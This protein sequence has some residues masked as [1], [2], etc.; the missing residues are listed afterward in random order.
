M[1][2]LTSPTTTNRLADL[3][4]GIIAAS[5]FAFS[6]VLS[7]LVMNAGA[8]VLTLSLFRGL[9]GVA[10]LFVWLRVG[11]PP[12]QHTP[13]QRWI[14]LGLGVLF[15]GVVFG[16]FAAFHAVTVAL[17]IL[18]Y[19]VY[20]LVT[21]LLGALLGI[22]RIGWRGALAALAA[23]C[24][25]ALMMRAHPQD[26]AIAGIAFALMAAACRTAILLITR[27]TLQDA[28]PQV[29]TWYTI[30]GSTVVL[31]MVAL[32]QWNWQGPQTP[33]GWAAMIGVSVGTTIAVLALFVSIKRIGPF[34]SALVM[35]LEPLLSTVFSAPVLGEVITPI[36]AVGGAVMLAALVSFQLRR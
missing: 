25:L 29:T 13:R 33:G 10:L 20:P 8:D 6:N 11:T 17:G 15:A 16:L 30:L 18:T 22:E 7:K 28:D 26:I 32:V 34:R 3:A 1:S 2:P 31:G 19:F 4:P 12:K 14:S 9:L 36:Q 24:G 21:G 23:F 27:A 35:F 5:T